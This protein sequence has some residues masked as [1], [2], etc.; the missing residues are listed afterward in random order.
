MMKGRSLRWWGVAGLV[1]LAGLCLLAG[2]LYYFSARVRTFHSRPLVL[3]QKPFNR[4]RI[5]AGEHVLVNA[6]ARSKAGIRSIELWVDGTFYFAQEAPAGQKLT[7]LPLMV[8][9]EPV[10]DGEHRL[11][12]R[13]I[14]QDGVDGQASIRVNVEKG[15]PAGADVSGGETVEAAFA[16]GGGGGSG[17]AGD[18]PR[19]GGLPSSGAPPAPADSPPGEAP[20]LPLP[21]DQPSAE[22]VGVKIEALALETGLAY[23]QLH[24]YAD[25]GDLEPQW[26]PDA[27]HDQSTDESFTLV[28]GTG[29]NV[30]EY[31]SGD[32]APVIMWPGNEA[33]PFDVTCVGVVE[34][35]TDS[36]SLGRVEILAAPDAWDGS[37]RR[38]ES[39]GGEGSFSLDYRMGLSSPT[40]GIPAILD[41]SITSPTNLRA[42]GASE[43]HWDW[44]PAADPPETPI[45]GFYV[46]V[47]GTLQFTITDPE[48]RSIILPPEWLTPPCGMDY[49]I[50]VSAW[51]WNPDDHTD[52]FESYPSE[53]L[54]IARDVL[55][56]CRVRA[57]VM[58][59]TLTFS[60][61]F[62]DEGRT[63]SLGPLLLMMGV[64][65][66]GTMHNLYLDGYCRSGGPGDCTGLRLEPEV[67][68]S[69]RTLMVENGGVS[70]VWV[71]LTS[72]GLLIDYVLFDQDSGSDELW[73]SGAIQIP[74]EELFTAEGGIDYTGTLASD[75]PDGR[76]QVEYSIR[77]ELVDSYDEDLRFPPLPSVGVKE[78]TTE[79]DRYW[80]KVHNYG[81][82]TWNYD[83]K[84]LMTRNS[85]EEIGTFT[86]PDF[87]LSPGEEVD[88][89]DPDR[90]TLERPMDMCVTLDPENAVLESVERDNPGWTFP[91]TCLEL[92]DL[93]IETAGFATES[94]PRLVITVQNQGSARME[95]NTIRIKAI[96][97][98]GNE[99]IFQVYTGSAGLYPW[100]SAPVE[101]DMSALEGLISSP[102]GRY[103]LTLIV[104]PNDDVIETN[105]ANNRFSFGDGA[106]QVQLF[107]NGFDYSAIDSRWGGYTF[108]GL[109]VTYYPYEDEHNWDYFHVR[110]YIDNGVE[111]RLAAQSDIDCFVARG[112]LYGGYL[113]SCQGWIN[114]PSA[115]PLA[116]LNLA[117]GERIHISISGDLYTRDYAE[118]T[119]ANTDRH[120]YDLGVIGIRF[121]F[122]EIEHHLPACG[123]RLPMGI[124]HTGAVW[125]PNMSYRWY[126]GFTLCAQ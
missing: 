34:G 25:M 72:E 20:E 118:L 104:D 125:P 80:I 48:A 105:E 108:T 39:E 116:T 78:I 93:V 95:T 85:G 26:Y 14:A 46:Y 55:E 32:Q 112:I 123:E 122:D 126:V 36:V 22:P 16:P 86:M 71:P 79:G 62:D 69:I 84:V 10:G 50:A 6:T 96:N 97:S 52:N 68:H 3:I 4:E 5:P 37:T 60:G 65:S 77:S 109:S 58:F 103:G 75:V 11:V 94:D 91:P 117:H 67:S 23:E 88:I 73:C 92:P 43:L 120:H 57:A 87:A 2:I 30:A 83:L 81:S 27:D 63:D 82:A 70:Y 13:A 99:R 102:E 51:R 8:P 41:F 53:P 56:E 21:A 106:R 18:P 100:E 7:D 114:S 40:M 19:G 66:G 29:W 9:W 110:V 15:Q 24:C 33:L 98:I 64:N 38:A 12:V 89:F 61:G 111:E 1:G 54:V 35:G 121:D 107:W 90:Q 28:G 44:V 124:S 17:G 119:G 49:N 42:E 31:L 76:C 113:H 59:E 101:I 47:N 45:D 115:P 74:R